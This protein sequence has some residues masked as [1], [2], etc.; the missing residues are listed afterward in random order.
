[1]DKDTNQLKDHQLDIGA[2][3]T[4]SDSLVNPSN[5]DFTDTIKF[6]QTYEGVPGQNLLFY[7][8]PIRKKKFL[9]EVNGIWFGVDTDGVAKM[10]VG[11]GDVNGS[12]F[13]GFAWN[14]EFFVIGGQLIIEGNT[15]SIEVVSTSNSTLLE[16]KGLAIIAEPSGQTIMTL[17]LFPELGGPNVFA[18]SFYDSGVL[19][20]Y[21]Y[22]SV[23]TG[24]H[25]LTIQEE[26]VVIGT[27]NMVVSGNI[28]GQSV[29]AAAV[30]SS[31]PAGGAGAIEIGSSGN[32]GIWFGS[33]APTASAGKGSWYLRTDGSASNNRMYINTNGSTTW[34]AVVTVA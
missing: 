7:G 20:G 5:I 3:L 2:D 12:D 27:N 30:L 10:I 32:L 11:F 14:G 4:A 34:T 13:V 33:G 21:I 26:T 19:Q 9:D 8:T 16:P 15:A 17:G 1:M 24:H 29:V 25:T 28:L 18:L 22:S 23:I 6:D 31:G